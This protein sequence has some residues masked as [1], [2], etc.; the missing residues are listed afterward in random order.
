MATAMGK[1]LKLYVESVLVAC[2]RENSFEGNTDTVS[3]TCKDSG[4]WKGAVPTKNG[5][6]VSASAVADFAATGGLETMM[7]FW[8]AQTKVDVDIKNGVMGDPHL[9]G[10]G[11][12]TS[13][14]FTAPDE[15]VVTY[16]ITIT[17]DGAAAFPDQA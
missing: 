9:T 5:W 3:T 6:S 8:I 7:D 15:D 12:I 1:D 14:S 4:I 13:I 17:G 2:L 11:Y 10:E 16:D